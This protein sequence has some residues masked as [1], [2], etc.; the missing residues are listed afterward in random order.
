MRVVPHYVTLTQTA[1]PAKP[2][3]PGPVSDSR[4]EVGR[5]RAGVRLDRRELADP[6]AGLDRKLD[7]VPEEAA[8]RAGV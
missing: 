2:C 4:R 3:L 8:V 1:G 7:V 5:R 6:G